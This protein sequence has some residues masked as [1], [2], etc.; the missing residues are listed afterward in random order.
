M[1][2]SKVAAVEN[3]RSSRAPSSTRQTIDWDRP[4]RRASSRCDQ[5]IVVRSILTAFPTTLI[6][7][8]S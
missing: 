6:G 4:A 8:E 5:P 1:A 7:F 2:F 3:V